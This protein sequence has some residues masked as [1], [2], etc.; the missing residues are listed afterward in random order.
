MGSVLLRPIKD[1]QNESLWIT[2]TSPEAVR[3]HIPEPSLFS[4]S[5]NM[6]DCL[7]HLSFFSYWSIVDVQ[8]YISYRCTT[9]WFTIF[10]DYTLNPFYSSLNLKIGWWLINLPSNPYLGSL[11]GININLSFLNESQDFV[12]IIIILQAYIS[13]RI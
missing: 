11:L 13:S 5:G 4:F 1:K 8:Y 6:S 12:G 2:S 7:M 3:R 10:K 9:Q